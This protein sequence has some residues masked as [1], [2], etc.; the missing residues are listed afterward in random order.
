M[1]IGRIGA[2]L[3]CM[4]PCLYALGLPSYIVSQPAP[5]AIPIVQGRVAAPILV[6]AT[7]WP[8]VVRAAGDLASDVERVTGIK[9]AAMHD[10]QEPGM[11]AIIVGT[12]GKSAL[13]DRL[14][15]EKRID[16]SRVAGEWEAF[17]VQ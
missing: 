6:D 2:L 8:G 16:V 1:K 7:D 15:R 11:N 4:T 12:I 10:A 5:G 9:P 14:I 13:I 3:C 17:V